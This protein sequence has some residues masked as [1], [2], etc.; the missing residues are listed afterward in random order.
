MGHFVYKHK[1]LKTLNVL[2]LLLEKISTMMQKH[3]AHRSRI[4][5]EIEEAAGFPFAGDVE[6]IDRLVE[7]W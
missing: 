7:R 3:V 2:S 4:A 5:A 6:G 1:S